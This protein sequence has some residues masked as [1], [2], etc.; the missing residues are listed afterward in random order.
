MDL[1]RYTKKNSATSA[2]SYGRLKYCMQCGKEV[3][4]ESAGHLYYQSFCSQ[5]CKDRYIGREINP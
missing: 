5:L 3:D 4:R 1:S 2:S